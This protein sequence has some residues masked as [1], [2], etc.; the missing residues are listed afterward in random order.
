M[1]SDILTAQKLLSTPSGLK[2]ECYNFQMSMNNLRLICFL[3]SKG[4]NISYPVY[5]TA[6]LILVTAE[7][8]II[9]VSYVNSA[10]NNNLPFF[11]KIFA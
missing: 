5:I 4:N 3:T 7:K 9:T 10:K 1:L 8:L 6:E 2:N 11:C